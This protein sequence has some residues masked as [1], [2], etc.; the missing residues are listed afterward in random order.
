MIKM[1]KMTKMTKKYYLLF[2]LGYL[3]AYTN[4]ETGWE[5]TEGTQQSF[6][7]FEN[8]NIDDTGAVGDGLPANN[9]SGE[10]INNLNTYD[11]IGCAKVINELKIYFDGTIKNAKKK[12]TYL[13]SEALF[14]KA[15][16]QIA[17][18]VTYHEGFK[19]KNKHWDSALKILSI[20]R[21]HAEVLDLRT[22]GHIFSEWPRLKNGK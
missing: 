19:E 14:L 18:L 17:Q 16:R 3:F 6:Y 20:L 22:H 11:V 9:Y 5:Y 7:M 21:I 15:V 12:D 1:I 10:C 4:N 2:L 8:I 13:S